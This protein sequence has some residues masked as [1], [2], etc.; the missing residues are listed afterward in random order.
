MTRDQREVKATLFDD[1]CKMAAIDVMAAEVKVLRSE[2]SR[3]PGMPRFEAE[4]TRA[5]VQPARKPQC[6]T[7]KQ[8]GRLMPDEDD[9]PCFVAYALPASGVRAAEWCPKGC[10]RKAPDAGTPPAGEDKQG[11]RLNKKDSQ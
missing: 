10:K 1:V 8:R 6:S 5:S 7:S 4:R 3:V 11:E 2:H 9:D